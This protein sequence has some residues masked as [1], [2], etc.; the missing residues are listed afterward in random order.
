MFVLPSLFQHYKLY[1]YFFQCPP[2]E[3]IV[4]LDVR[5]LSIFQHWIHPNLLWFRKPEYMMYVMNY[6]MELIL[7]VSF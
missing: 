5:L 3:F 2:Q 1:E 6:V 4:G 7:N